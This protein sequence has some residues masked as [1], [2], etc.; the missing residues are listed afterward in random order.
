M[1]PD[2]ERLRA[3]ELH[4][5]YWRYQLRTVMYFL[6]DTV[7][8]ISLVFSIFMNRNFSL[9]IHTADIISL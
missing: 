6:S 2:S 7:I 9:R 8:L 1:E 3:L 5:T 4:S